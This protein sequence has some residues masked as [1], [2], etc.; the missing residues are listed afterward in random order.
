MGVFVNLP[1]ARRMAE[2][3]EGSL[4]LRPDWRDS[5]KQPFALHYENIM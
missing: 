5:V 1:L 2:A 3:I 4:N